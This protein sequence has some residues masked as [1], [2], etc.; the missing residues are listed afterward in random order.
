MAWRSAGSGRRAILAQG[1]ASTPWVCST[2]RPSCDC[3]L[4]PRPRAHGPPASPVDPRRRR[5][6][7]REIR[8]R[9]G[10]P[11]SAPSSLAGA[12]GSPSTPGTPVEADVTG[13][14]CSRCRPARGSSGTVESSRAPPRL[15][16]HPRRPGRPTSGAA[17]SRLL[18]PP[19]MVTVRLRGEEGGPDVLAGLEIVLAVRARAPGL[20]FILLSGELHVVQSA[21]RTVASARAT[22][23]LRRASPS[24]K[25]SIRGLARVSCSRRER[26][27]SL[28]APCRRSLGL[29]RIPRRIVVVRGARTIVPRRPEEEGAETRMLIRLALGEG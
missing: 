22:H 16:C 8:P 28:T 9:S 2:R 23:R 4:P 7:V 19:C 24:A 11:V 29:T 26:S 27:S 17:A 14:S 5:A 13:A 18:S 20:D 15:R 10:S 3:V 12:T 1:E 25:R 6:R 21:S